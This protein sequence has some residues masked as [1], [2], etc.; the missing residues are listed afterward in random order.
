MAARRPGCPPSAPEQV[1]IDRIGAE[2][3]GVAAAPDGARLFV[4]LTLPGETVAVRR[5]GKRGDGFAATAEA[6][7][8]PSPDRVA[9][10]CPHFGSCGGCALQH[11]QEAPYRAWKADLLSA[12]LRRA[13]YAEAAPAPLL[14]TPPA[15]R[16]R[17]DFAV[18]RRGA[19]LLLGL[20]V[21]HGREVVDLTGCAVLHPALATLL[22]PLRRLLAGLAGLRREGSVI[23]NLLATGPD[24]LLRTDAA[25]TAADRA[26]LADFA[27]AHA[28]PRI[29]WAQG[30]AVPEIAA[31]LGPAQTRFAGVAV[32][33]PPGAFL[34]AS[35]E[36]EAAIVAAV[37]AALPAR[38]PPRARIAELFA[39]CGTLTFPLAEQARVAAFEGDAAAI[40]ALSAAANHAGRAGRIAATRR[41]LA[42][43]PLSAAELS[44]FAAVVLDP[45]HAGAA[46]QVAQIAASR[47][48]SVIYVSC[49]PGALARDAATLRAAGFRL[50]AAQPIDQFRW[51]ARLE[52]VVAFGR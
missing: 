3:D 44:P 17:M 30:D 15:S 43:Q 4:P 5:D 49:H 38:L 46:A 11:W 52:S 41:D 42:R 10:P 27:R 34:Q 50:L 13:G 32:S 19:A 20:H 31:Q 18:R 7:L 2:G 23:A 14:A 28:L 40:A 51:S 8:A 35:A 1:R 26:R 29:A 48:A 47:V 9:P 24:L 16:R 36:G 12:A 39:G 25:L 37:L 33:P 45:P 6:I 21:A 22:A